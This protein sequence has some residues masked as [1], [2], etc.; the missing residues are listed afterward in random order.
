VQNCNSTPF[1]TTS[2]EGNPRAEDYATTLGIE[3]DMTNRAWR[4]LELFGADESVTEDEFYAYKYDMTYSALGDMPSYIQL[5]LDAPLPEDADVQRALETVRSWDLRTNPESTGAA[6]VIWTL[7]SLDYPAPEEIDHADLAEAFV[8][9][10]LLL[11]EAHGRVDVPWSEVNRLRRGDLDLGMGGG[12]D[13]LHAVSGVQQADGRIVG[14]QG[15][16]FV[17][18]VTWDAAGQ[19]HSRSIHQYGTA[20]LDEASPHFADQAPLFV[21]RQLK[22]VWLDESDIREHL[23]R[24]YRPGEE[25]RGKGP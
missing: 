18:L 22:P 13:I 17:M 14:S 2:G 12:P 23:E 6:L 19:V 1:R 11:R 25:M 24:E 4:A 20:T 5:L 21:G 7:A 10:A 8:E 9:T 16:S 3:V 15:D